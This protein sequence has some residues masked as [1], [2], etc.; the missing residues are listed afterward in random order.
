MPKEKESKLENIKDEKL[1]ILKTKLSKVRTK[2]N[3][4][5]KDLLKKFDKYIV[6]IALLPPR[7]DNKEL[8]DILILVDDSDSKKMSKLELKDRLTAISQNMAKDIDKNFKPEMILLS[9]MQQNCYDGKFEFLKDLGMAATVYDPKD[10]IAGLKVSAVHKEMVMKKFEKYIVSYVAAGSLFRGEKSNDIDVYVIVDDTDVKKMSRFELKDKLRAIILSQAFEANT[11]TRVTKKFHV[12]VYILT[13]FWEGIKDANPVFFTLLR[14]GIPLY[15]R[16]V[17]MPWKL[18][19]E[20]GRIKPSPEAI[21][22]FISSGDKMMERIRF[23]L[24]EIVEADIYWSTLTPSQAALMM[25]GVAPPTPKETI[26]I[27]DDIFVKKEKL[28]EKKYIDILS[29]IRKYYKDL[30]YEK[31]KNLSGKDIDRLVKNA[32]DYL[33]RIKKLFAQIEKRKEEENII[34]I[35]E[36]S[37]KLVKDVLKINEIKTQNLET[38]LKKL[39]DKNEIPAKTIKEFQEIIK[40]KKDYKNLNKLE[41]NK[42]RKDSK[43]FISSLFE[44]IQRKKGKELEKAA[45]RIKYDTNKFAEVIL[46]D[47]TAFIIHDLNKRDEITKASLNKDGSL[48]EQTKSNIKE[49]EQHITKKRTPKNVFI[50]EA[51]FE[52]LKKLLGKDIEIL[53]SY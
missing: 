44:Y 34:E 41:I 2:L 42:I 30:E 36:T 35:Y 52:S 28:L 22:M 38:G 8:I 51:T 6:G 33:K 10:L 46:L 43:F 27:M 39:K 49:L 7:K 26:Q 37:N 24:R 9:E 11:I 53:V 12:Q 45:I 20:M 14:D 4:L 1:D 47:G 32:Q 3:K 29:E 50:K 13:D 31:I 17:F 23:K 48:N 16:G 18:L 25:Y 19:L 15:D 21:D 5:K 40:A